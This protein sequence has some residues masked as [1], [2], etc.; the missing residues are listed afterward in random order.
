MAI[1]EL[2][3]LMESWEKMV[4]NSLAYN[5]QHNGEEEH[6]WEHYAGDYESNRTS[7]AHF[8]H[9]V[10][11]LAAR[12][13]RDASVLEIGPGPV[14]FTLPLV[15]RCRLVT[16]V[17]PSPSLAARIGQTMQW[18]PNLNIVRKCWEDVFLPSHDFIFSAGTLHLFAD[19]RGVLEKMLSHARLKVLLV[20]LDEDRTFQQETADALQLNTHFPARLLSSL[21][22][23]VLE[24]L[25]LFFTWET[26]TEEQ[27]Y[28]YPNIDLLINVWQ[29]GMNIDPGRR[30]DLL[31]FF[32]N[33]G[34]CDDIGE[35]ITLPRRFSSH[36]VEIFV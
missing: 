3:Q 6:Y 26:F 20:L 18:Y 34:L 11:W 17:E 35:Q 19:I 30:H 33:K 7:G 15:E 23:Q 1:S 27:T 5:R 28:H 13:P 14:I 10:E 12:I 16:V 2:E 9:V 29:E 31:T 4:L 24:C 36:L 22:S 8:R 25:G 21:F 32:R